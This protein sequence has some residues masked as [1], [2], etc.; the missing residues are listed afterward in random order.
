MLGDKLGG[1]ICRAATWGERER[2]WRER[3]TMGSTG[4]AIR[5]AGAVGVAAFLTP[6]LVL[7]ATLATAL[8]Q[9]G[10]PVGGLSFTVLLYLALDFLSFR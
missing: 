1:T 10:L 8:R 5:P 4:G 9:L 7:A 6:C 2:A 3:N